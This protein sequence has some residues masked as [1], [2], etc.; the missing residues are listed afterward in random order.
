MPSKN[1]VKTYINDGYYHIY[2]RGVAK[3]DIFNDK[4]DYT[5]FLGYLKDALNKPKIRKTIKYVQGRT[6]SVTE[7][8]VKNFKKEITL[9]AYCLMPNH[10]HFL[11]M[12]K[13]KEAMKSFMQS[14]ITRYSSYFNKKY[15][16]VGPLFQGRYKAIIIDNDNYLLHLSRYIHLNSLELSR[17]LVN[18]YSSYSIYLDLK[19]SKWVNPEAVLAFFD[20]K[21]NKD[22]IK[23]NNYKHF[24]ER[25]QKDS[26]EVLGELTLE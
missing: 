5:V 2:N 9:I 1:I 26:A 6:L 11:I 7:R 16:R 24:V 22:F 14:V 13:N 3:Q 20:N 8:P 18:A 19:K 23:T 17:D 15:K 4:K 25:Y 21:N 12:Q 10:F